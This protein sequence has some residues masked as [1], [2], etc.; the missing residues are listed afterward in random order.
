MITIS[1]SIIL[2]NHFY[3]KVSIKT[4]IQKSFLNVAFI[5]YDISNYQLKYANVRGIDSDFKDDGVWSDKTL[6]LSIVGWKSMQRSLYMWSIYCCSFL[7]KF[8]ENAIKNY[9]DYHIVLLESVQI[10][11]IDSEISSKTP[12]IPEQLLKDFLEVKKII[13]YLD[14]DRA[15]YL[16]TKI[17]KDNPWYMA[18]IAHILMDMWVVCTINCTNSIKFG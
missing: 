9:K 3:I 5:G 16:A 1:L 8:I 2:T 6:F 7:C 14:N 4:V 11:C 10:A 12:I 18:V 15:D 13:L 17:I